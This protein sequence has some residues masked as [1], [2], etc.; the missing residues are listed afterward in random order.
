MSITRIH[1]APVRRYTARRGNALAGC[2]VVLGVIVVLLIGGGVFVAMNWRDWTA[3]GM[4]AVAT[5]L[6]EDA[7]LPEG[8]K[9]EVLAIV[10]DLAGEFREG[11]LGVE[12]FGQVMQSI[13]E[14][15][16]IPAAIAA[17]V[18]QQYF[19]NAELSDE[20]KAEA[21]LQLDRVS[22]GL[23][24]GKIRQT[25]L[26]AILEP[27]SAP[28]AEAPVQINTGEATLNL[29]A[30][31]DCTPE[32]LRQVIENART[33]ADEAEIPSERYEFDT[34]DELSRAIRAA[35]GRDLPSL[36]GSQGDASNDD[37]SAPEPSGQPAEDAGEEA[38]EQ[39]DAD[40]AP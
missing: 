32:E 22:R 38:G 37:M 20:E 2:L 13:A 9:Q 17:S 24:E 19:A 10:E 5:K 27:I 31:S 3:G 23:A 25:R 12:E 35:L 39:P 11:R 33:Q 1:T 29:K 8:E 40:D 15:P 16:I 6:V 7:Q 28:P 18:D 30:A 14:G 4:T 21:R 26:P 34:S 36:T